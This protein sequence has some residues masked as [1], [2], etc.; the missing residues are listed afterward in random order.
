MDYICDICSKRLPSKDSMQK[1]IVVHMHKEERERL[2]AANTCGL[3]SSKF[4]S[5]ST[6]AFHIRN[7][8]ERAREIVCHICA[9]M[10]SCKDSYQMH[11][12]SV[13]L[14]LRLQCQICG[15]SLGSI[16]TLKRHLKTKHDD[17][18]PH[19]C[20]FDNCKYETMSL[21]LF[22]KHQKT[23]SAQR[24]MYPCQLCDKTFFR[25]QGLREHIPTHSGITLYNCGLCQ[26]ASNSA[27]NMKKHKKRHHPNEYNA[28]MKK[29]KEMKIG[30]GVLN[31]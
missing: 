26:Y 21:T 31:D 22:Q 20:K 2:K 30:K 7:K 14:N 4:F 10:F 29:V 17:S 15:D 5:A 18:G 12:K 13:H 23:H 28:F 1:H 24:K 9:K 16:R 8:H 11:Y 6:L 25:R 3:C 19:L 27:E